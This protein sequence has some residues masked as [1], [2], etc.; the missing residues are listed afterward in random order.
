MI[1]LWPD[2]ILCYIFRHLVALNVNTKQP[3][4]DEQESS[5]TNRTFILFH[6]MTFLV[7]L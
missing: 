3:Y 4:F 7:L 5:L 1:L 6:K 2:H